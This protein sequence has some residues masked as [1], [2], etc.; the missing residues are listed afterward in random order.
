MSKKEL[1]FPNKKLERRAIKC[2]NE[3]QYNL[4]EGRLKIFK[5][6]IEALYQ[7]RYM[8]LCLY[9]GCEGIEAGRKFWSLVQKAEKAILKV[10]Q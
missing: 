2:I 5:N 3:S 4:L 8:A 1:P 9:N 7:T 10:M 6:S